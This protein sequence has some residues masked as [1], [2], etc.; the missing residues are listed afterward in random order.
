MLKTDSLFDN[1]LFVFAL[2]AEA[3][4]LFSND[5]VLYTG[6]GKLNAAYSLTKKILTNRPS[7]IINLGSA[8][9]NKFAKESIICCTQFVQRD[10]DAALL[11]YQLYETPFSE[12]KNKLRYGIN[13]LF[14]EEG[15]CGS[16]DNFEVE[17]RS[18]FYD[19]VDMEAY[20]LAYISK[21]EKIP[22]LC[23][24]YITDGADDSAVEDWKIMVDKAA[25]ALRIS[26]NRVINDYTSERS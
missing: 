18:S 4:V 6:V 15:I 2:E 13:I 24:K 11:G 9:S 7:I 8:G 23:L 1:P 3:G 10:M 25:K 26:V 20:A 19:V 21:K 12:E 16:G 22:F 14:L 5:N 17:H